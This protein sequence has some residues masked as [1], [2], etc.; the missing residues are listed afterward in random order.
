MS[1]AR[2]QTPIRHEPRWNLGQCSCGA[3]LGDSIDWTWHLSNESF[4]EGLRAA[5]APNPTAVEREEATRRICEVLAD[6]NFHAVSWRC[7]CGWVHPQYGVKSMDPA[8]LQR[9]V[10]EALIET[11]VIV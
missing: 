5:G 8:Y 4:R 10:A 1:V 9:H 2:N 6:H 11:G 7:A 3:K